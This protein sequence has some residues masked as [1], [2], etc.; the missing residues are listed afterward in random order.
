M[1][2]MD[3]FR[4]ERENVKKKSFPD[5][6]KYFWYY[7]KWYL[8]A[9]VVVVI[10]AINIIY[11][12]IIHKDTAFYAAFLNSQKISAGSQFQEGFE[13]YIEIDP[14]K[15][16]VYFDTSIIINENVTKE[17]SFASSQKL[18]VYTASSELDAIVGGSDIFPNYA[19]G[20]MFIDLREILN[21]EQL[22]KYEPYFYYID[23]AVIEALDEAYTTAQKDTIPEFAEPTKPE[24]MKE[25]IPVGIFVTD[26]SKLTDNY[27]FMGDYVVLGVIGNTARLE[28]TLKFIEYIFE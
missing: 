19:Y 12:I 23:R 20:D 9:C 10:V 16:V 27:Q 4:E 22:A 8:I 2:L 6:I 28:N 18:L 25:P 26:C 24:E 5:R 1:P 3:E 21:E 7:Y 14:N 11:S 13:E 15:Y 17:S